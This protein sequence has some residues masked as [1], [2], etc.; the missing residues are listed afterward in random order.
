MYWFH[1][2]QMT[3]LFV[4]TV[5]AH[6]FNYVTWSQIINIMYALT[7]YNHISLPD[8]HNETAIGGLLFSVAAGRDV[9]GNFVTWAVWFQ[10]LLLSHTML[11][12][13]V[14]MFLMNT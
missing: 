10:Q 9:G 12:P 13:V 4:H 11:F 3:T 7:K 2:L 8:F 14:E 5:F 6:R 1:H